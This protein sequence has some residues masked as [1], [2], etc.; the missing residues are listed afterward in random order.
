MKIVINSCYGGFGLSKQARDLLAER[1]FDPAIQSLKNDPESKY[2][3]A[4]YYGTTSEVEFRSHP[5]VI[6]VIEELGEKANGLNSKLKIIELNIENIID[7]Y[8]FDGKEK[9][10]V[11][12]REIY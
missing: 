2:S 12:G 6:Q 3:F 11:N 7:I 10:L 8:N 9:I 4:N 1:G 5:L